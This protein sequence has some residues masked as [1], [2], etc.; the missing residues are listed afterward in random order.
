MK[1][2]MEI[3]KMTK[4]TMN[5][6]MKMTMKMTMILIKIAIYCPQGSG[7][8]RQQLSILHDVAP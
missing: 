6:T 7:T 1:M 4:M 8:L 5:M 2:K 3:I